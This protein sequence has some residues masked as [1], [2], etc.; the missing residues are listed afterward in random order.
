M[1]FEEWGGN[2]SGITMVRRTI[3]SACADVSEWHPSLWHIKSL[4]K[5]EMPEK[6]KVHISC[7]EGQKISSIKFASFGTPQGTCGSFQQGVC[8]STYSYE[9]FKVCLQTLCVCVCVC[10]KQSRLICYVFVSAG[11]HRAEVVLCCCLKRDLR[12]GSM[13]RHHEA[14]SC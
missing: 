6:P 5:P 2:P 10:L 1:I 12:R 14:S 9:A 7:T 3:G 4:G 8:H 11:M 13:P